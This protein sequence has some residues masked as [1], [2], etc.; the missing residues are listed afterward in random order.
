MVSLSGFRSDAH[1]GDYGPIRVT[2]EQEVE[3][4]ESYCLMIGRYKRH[5][6]S[7]QLAATAACIAMHL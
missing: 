7:R 2:E 5:Q 4:F 1:F 6:K 3:T